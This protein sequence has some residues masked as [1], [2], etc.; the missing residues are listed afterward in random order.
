MVEAPVPTMR[1]TLL[2]AVLAA[3]TGFQF[4][5]PTFQLPLPK[6]SV[7]WPAQQAQ[8]QVELAQQQ[9]ERDNLIELISKS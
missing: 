6:V 7:T 8:Q 5:L 4:Q 9:Q 2:L 3:A 1:C